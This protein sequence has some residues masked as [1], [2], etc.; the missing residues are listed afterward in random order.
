MFLFGLQF[1]TQDVPIC[2]RFRE[3]DAC[4]VNL[5]G[6]LAGAEWYYFG[7]FHGVSEL[8]RNR[9]CVAVLLFLRELENFKQYGR[10]QSLPGLG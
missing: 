5:I 3:V 2:S 9:A 6:H 4:E 1:Q 10:W 7:C 8:S